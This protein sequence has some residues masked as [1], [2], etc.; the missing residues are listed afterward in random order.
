MSGAPQLGY[1]LKSARSVYLLRITSPEQLFSHPLRGAI[2]EN[3]VVSEKIKSYWNDGKEAPVYFWRD[4]KGHEVDLV[5]DEG[6]S[7]YPIEIKSGATFNPDFIEGLNYLNRLQG[8]SDGEVI[9]GGETSHP[10]K[11]YQVRSWRTI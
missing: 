7:L 9:Y 2:F 6:T 11:E 10:F 4:Q 5:I 8:R 1:P 3:W